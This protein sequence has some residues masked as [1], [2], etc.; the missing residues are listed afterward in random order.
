MTGRLRW[1]PQALVW[2]IACMAQPANPDDV[3]GIA[4]SD[5]RRSERRRR[6]NAILRSGGR[7]GR[8]G[9]RSI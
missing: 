2:A 9:Q 7:G 4:Q 1:N 3:V 5:S 6:A 8:S